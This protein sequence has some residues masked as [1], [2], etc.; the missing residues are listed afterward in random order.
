MFISL[1]IL[2]LLESIYLFIYLFIYLS[3]SF[4]SIFSILLYTDHKLPQF[5]KKGRS[6]WRMVP[7]P[8][9][10]FLELIQLKSKL[11]KDLEFPHLN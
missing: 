1:K 11:D 3:L 2:Q 7:V 9:S 8:S 4:V 10:L 5:I 6:K